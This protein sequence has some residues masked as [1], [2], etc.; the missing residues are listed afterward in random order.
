MLLLFVIVGV[1]PLWPTGQVAKLTASDPARSAQFGSAVAISGSTLLVGAHQDEETVD[2][3]DDY[4]AA[5]VF[6]RDPGGSDNWIEVA[7]LLPSTPVR[8]ANFGYAVA[9]DGTTALVGAYRENGSVGGAQGAAYIFER[10]EGGTGNW[11]EVAKLTPS[12]I[13]TGDYFGCSV[14]LEGS[15]ALIG[16]CR[17]DDA[18]GVSGSAYIFE[19]DGS[20]AWNQIVK[21]IGDDTMTMDQF[22]TSVALSGNVAVVGSP[23][24]SHPT[25]ISGA[26]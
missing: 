13:E 11:G 5:Y 20:G 19:R 25:S 4:G 7:K 21:L 24:H 26:A 17:D 9:L 8:R 10:N 16:A 23:Q 3:G 22:G 12:S 18:G 15:R 6:E 2:D 14:A 1:S